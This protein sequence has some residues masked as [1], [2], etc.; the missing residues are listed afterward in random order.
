MTTTTPTLAEENLETLADRVDTAML[1][2]QKLSDSDRTKALDLKRA[3]EDFHRVGV[4]KIVQRLK[5]DPRGKEILFELV[6]VPEVYALFAMHGIVR[7]DLTT[8]AA[9]VLEMVRPY[10]RSHGGDVEL[11]KVEDDTAYV[12]LHGACNGCSMSAVTLRNGVEEALKEHLPQIK[13]VEVVPS[14]PEAGMIMLDSVV[15]NGNGGETSQ[16]G[17]WVKGPAVADVAEGRPLALETST[18][19][20]LIVRLNNQFFAYKN[21]CAHMGMPLDGGMLDTES[22]ILTCPWHGFKFDVT[23][24][25]CMTAPQAQLEPYPLRV[26]DEHVWVRP[27]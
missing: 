14:E 1:E 21:E 12:K 25:E 17:G 10:M 8:Q 2:V 23:S 20:V 3:I 4:T 9:R 18:G 11:V 15:V 16:L 22:C 6:D 24:G 26:Q 19:S 5:T 27:D 13:Q 7:A